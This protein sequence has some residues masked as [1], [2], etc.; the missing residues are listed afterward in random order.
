MSGYPSI[1]KLL[2]ELRRRERERHKRDPEVFW[3]TDLCRCPLKRIFEIE[4]PEFQKV[5]IYT[6]V[7]V[8]GDLVHLGLQLAIMKVAD[9]LKGYNISFEVEGS[10]DVD[11]GSTIVRVE[12]RA[13]CILEGSDRIGYEFKTS[14]GDTGLP[15]EHHILQCSLYNWMF[16][17]DFSILVYVTPDRI[18]EYPVMEKASDSLVAEL[19]SDSLKLKAPRYPWEC[20]FCQFAQMCSRKVA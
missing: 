17:L 1:Q 19:I 2:Y 6:P 12:G 14:R 11:M 4:Y 9:Q 13:D 3:I 18:C 15:R 20:K 16:D 10:K 5:S 7:F 8:L